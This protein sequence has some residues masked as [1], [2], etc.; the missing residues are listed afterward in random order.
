MRKVKK[1]P[2]ISA[3]RIAAE[4]DNDFEKTVSQE[5]KPFGKEM[6][7]RCAVLTDTLEKE[8]LERGKEEISMKKKTKELQKTS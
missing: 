1:N 4:I 3:S 8:V 5:R 2:M 7:W 6:K